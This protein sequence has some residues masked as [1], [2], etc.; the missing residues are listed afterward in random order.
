MLHRETPNQSPARSFGHLRRCPEVTAPRLKGCF[1]SLTGDLGPKLLHAA[2]I[3]L[4]PVR[5]PVQRGCATLGAALSSTP[6][7]P[8]D[9]GLIDVPNEDP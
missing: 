7:T 9:W 5:D 4:G 8:P 2:R 6:K 3:P 1:I